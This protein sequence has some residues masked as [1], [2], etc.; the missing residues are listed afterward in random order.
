MYSIYDNTEASSHKRAKTSP[1]PCSW[2]RPA[3]TTSPP[4]LSREVRLQ[5]GWKYH[6]VP[7]LMPKLSQERI[8]APFAEYNCTEYSCGMAQA[9]SRRQGAGRGPVYQIEVIRYPIWLKQRTRKWLL[10]AAPSVYVRMPFFCSRLGL[11]RVAVKMFRDGD[12]NNSKLQVKFYNRYNITMHQTII[13][14]VNSVDKLRNE[15][16]EGVRWM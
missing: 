2:A 4:H 9:S 1:S 10:T 8:F 13:S 14:F 15:F 11:S 7:K 5:T 3:L 12:H 16:Q 6:A